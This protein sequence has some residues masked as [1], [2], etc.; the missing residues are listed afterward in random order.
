MYHKTENITSS[1]QSGKPNLTIVGQGNVGSHLAN[2]FSKVA[3]VTCVCSRTLEGLPKNSDIIIIAVK[4]DAII[5]TADRIKGCAPLIAHTSGS[6]PMDAVSGFA[7]SCGVLYPMQTFTKDVPLDYSSVPFFIEG[8][9]LASA[10][11]LH[12]LASMVSNNVRYANSTDRKK[13]HVAAV[14]TCN[15]TNHM[16]AIADSLLRENGM[17]Y[18]VMMPLLKQTIA[19]LDSIAPGKA[20][21]GPAARND[22]SV[23]QSHLKM[24]EEKPETREL[25]D[26]ITKHI[27]Q[28]S[29]TK[30]SAKQDNL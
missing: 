10:E 23:I 8:D 17:D 5:S 27:I 29:Y 3:N 18:T 13:L 9:S 14:F 16:V 7:E 22:I 1:W 6:I 11:L 20:Q 2:A 28:S 21:T 19:K 4:D 30:Q 24:L 15:F 26:M 12:K 25:Y